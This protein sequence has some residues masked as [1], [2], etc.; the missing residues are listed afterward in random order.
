MRV[1][2]M[3]FSGCWK[4]GLI[5]WKAAANTKAYKTNTKKAAVNSSLII[6]K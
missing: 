5:I 4:K 2:G 1:C 6:K 3:L